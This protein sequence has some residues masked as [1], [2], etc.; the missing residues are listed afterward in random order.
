MFK[1]A[2]EF[3]RPTNGKWYEQEDKDLQICPLWFMFCCFEVYEVREVTL[4]DWR[5]R[6]LTP[7]AV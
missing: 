7:V 4:S 1:H 5:F 6:E 3:T 2:W